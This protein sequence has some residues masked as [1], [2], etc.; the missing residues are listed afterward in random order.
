MSSESAGC[1]C[2]HFMLC[3]QKATG[4]VPSLGAAAAAACVRCKRSPLT[5]G[6][7]SCRHALLSTVYPH[8]AARMVGFC[9]KVPVQFSGVQF[10]TLRDKP[11]PL[12]VT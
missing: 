2:D 4:G 7:S 9:Q 10:Y 6:G 11:L 5:E 3:A 1:A 8:G 12:A